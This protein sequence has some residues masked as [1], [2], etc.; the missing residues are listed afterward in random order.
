[1]VA[2]KK[3]K[4]ITNEGIPVSCVRELH[5]LNLLQSSELKETPQLTLKL[6]DVYQEKNEIEMVV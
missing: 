1:M 2:I 4:N 5:V 3:F 6:Y